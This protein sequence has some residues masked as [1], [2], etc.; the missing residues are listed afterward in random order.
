MRASAVEM[1]MDVVDLP[2]P[3]FSLPTTM[4]CATCQTLSESKSAP[5]RPARL[6]HIL[7]FARRKARQRAFAACVASEPE[8]GVLVLELRHAASGVHQAGAA[9]GPGGVD[10][11][12]DVERERVSFLAPGRFH[13]HHGAIGH[14]DI[15]DVVIGM[16]VC[17]HRSGPYA[18][19]RF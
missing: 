12:I 6:I 13:L 4:M 16:D 7:W 10:G 18:S 9:T 5:V 1:C 2:E 17:F 14:L 3:P 19:A 15:D 8:A 11:R